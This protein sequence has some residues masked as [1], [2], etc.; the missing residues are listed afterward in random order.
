[1]RRRIGYKTRYRS[2]AGIVYDILETLYE[3]GMSLPTRLMYGARIPYD[4]LK[5]LLAKLEESG[6]I[7][8]EEIEGKTYYKL[9]KKGYEALE[10]LRR[11][12]RL[13]ENIGIRF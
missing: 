1:M 13:L 9:T 11:V 5:E 2:Q 8:K 7:E 12:R 6:L 10:E 4:R 3:E